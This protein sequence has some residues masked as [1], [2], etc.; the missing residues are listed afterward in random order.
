[1]PTDTNVVEGLWTT[2]SGF[3]ALAAVL[4]TVLSYFCWRPF[5]YGLGLFG[6]QRTDEE[7]FGLLVMELE[8]EGRAERLRN[9]LNAS[10]PTE[11]SSTA[12]D[13]T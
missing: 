5:L 13:L 2:F 1:M 3:G 4:I 12:E 8:F 9:E 6:V 7:R 11:S 10:R